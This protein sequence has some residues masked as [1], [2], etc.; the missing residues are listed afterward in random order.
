LRML[1]IRHIRTR[2]YTRKTKRQGRALHPDDAARMG[3]R[4][5]LQIFRYARRRP[6]PMALVV[7]PRI[8]TPIS[9]CH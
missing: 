4:H 6:R 3:L 7:Q 9:L 2:P 1:G 5:S 8:R